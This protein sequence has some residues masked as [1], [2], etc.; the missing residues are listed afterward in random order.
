MI[1]LDSVSDLAR[2]HWMVTYDGEVEKFF[3]LQPDTL[4]PVLRGQ[5]YRVGH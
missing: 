4:C 5:R 2:Q 1:P 3:F